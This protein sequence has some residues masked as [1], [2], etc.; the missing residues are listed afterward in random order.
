ML[1]IVTNVAQAIE[2]IK[3]DAKTSL[4]N[5][6]MTLF[7]SIVCYLSNVNIA[8]KVE[9]PLGSVC[10]VCEIGKSVCD[11]WIRDNSRNFVNA[12]ISPARESVAMA[13]VTID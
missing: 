8:R 13:Q 11:L 3:I 1:T 2:K 5:S 7:C 10:Y 4:I 9:F 12:I 6:F